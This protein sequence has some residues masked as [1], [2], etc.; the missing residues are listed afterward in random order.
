[1]D[2]TAADEATATEAAAALGGLWLSSGSSA[3]GAPPARPASLSAPMRTFAVHPCRRQPAPAP[4]EAPVANSALGAGK[5]CP[6]TDL[7][8]EG[9][10]D[11]I[12]GPTGGL[13]AT[14]P[15]L[16]RSR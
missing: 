5:G 14:T 12:L 2:I 3:P 7:W 11:R 13:W 16:R 10:R 4:A 8:H 15:G 6:V 9:G 1:M